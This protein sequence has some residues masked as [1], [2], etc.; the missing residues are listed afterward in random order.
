MHKSGIRCG[1]SALA[2]IVAISNI[3]NMLVL[4]TRFDPR[5]AIGLL[6]CNADRFVAA[7][8]FISCNTP[9]QLI[10][11]SNVANVLKNILWS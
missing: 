1:F 2:S 7:A 9:C 5:L 6:V 3:N 10:W 8:I 11:H 4:L